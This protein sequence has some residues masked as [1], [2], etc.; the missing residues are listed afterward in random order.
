MTTDVINRIVGFV[1]LC[2]VQA[3]VLNHIHI[4]GFATPLLYV[5]M[6]LQFRRNYPKRGI[7]LWCFLLGMVIDTFSNTPGVSSASLLVVA[8]IQPYF[9]ELFL[10]RDSAEDFRPSA[11]SLGIAKYIFYLFVLLVLYSTVFFT[12]ESFNFF[13]WQQ[14]LKCIF[15]STVITISLILTIETAR[16]K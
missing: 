4:F 2:L 13:N 1:V 14:W 16:K 7:L 8:A 10:Q 12:L 11:K 15:G 5:Y 3:L 6:V 9:L